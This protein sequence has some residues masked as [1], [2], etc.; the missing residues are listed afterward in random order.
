MNLFLTSSPGG[1]ILEGGVK[2]QGF[3]DGSNGFVEELRALWHENMHGLIIAAFPDSFEQ[4]DYDADAFTNAFNLSG[5]PVKSFDVYDHRQDEMSSGDLAEY[6]I[7]ILSGGHVPTQNNFFKQIHL[8]E[9]I[10]DFDGI[11]I[12]ISAGTMNCASLVYAMPELDG[13]SID[14]NYKRFIVGLGLSDYNI[15]PHYDYLKDITLDGK[16]MIGDIACADS[17]G[18]EF[19]A[20]TDGS[21]ILI[22]DNEKGVLYGESYRI[23]DGFVRPLCGAGQ[24]ISLACP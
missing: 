13:E 8:A 21:Y 20:L 7:I 18:R 4:N 5:L 6:D 11:I 1:L 3:L 24:H 19:I 9:N 23:S 22:K 2:K 16:K 17:E 10:S 12:G 14:K 15:I